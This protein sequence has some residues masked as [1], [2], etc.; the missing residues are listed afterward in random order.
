[1]WNTIYDKEGALVPNALSIFKNEL[2][3]NHQPITKVEFLH[4]ATMQPIGATL[5]SEPRGQV[6]NIISDG[7]IDVDVERGT[8]RTAEITLLN[9]SGDFTPGTAGFDP[10]GPWTGVVY[11]N[12]VVRI[13][14]GVKI[15]DLELY[16]PV[17]TFMVDRAETTVEQNMSLVNLTLSDFWK[18]LTKSSFS[19]NK[20]YD[21]GTSYWKVVKDM[22]NNS[23]VSSW[24]FSDL[25]DRDVSD[26]TTGNL[27][28][29]R[30]DV[31]GEKLK[32][33]GERW[34]L[35]FYFDPM[36]HFRADDR[37]A[38]RDKRTTWWFSSEP[39]D[40]GRHGGLVSITRS[41]SDD[42]IYNHVVVI[43]T[44]DEKNVVRETRTDESPSSKLSIE[45]LGRRTKIVESD[46]IST[47]NQAKRAISR[48]W[49]RR[50]RISETINADTICNPLLEAD[51]VVKFH[52][53]QFAKV[54]GTYRVRRFSV[55]L[56]TSKQT[57]EAE[58]Y[59]R[60]G[61]FK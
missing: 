24:T 22:L 21:K 45:K 15:G 53:P 7:N 13:W 31:R 50:N 55:P 35:D 2:R 23:G 33:L 30:G 3:F 40:D 49:N 58:N 28:F 11:L 14:R 5:F 9:P 34:D 60:S 46:K 4:T 38:P 10:D 16:A 37:L 61:D 27:K 20:K 26:R 19:A 48:L 12:R 29:S 17:G 42:Q 47:T 57:L 59:L 25:S 44:G 56:V 41:F 6:Q 1:M 32:E 36:G 18:K 43:G 39:V 51:D 52:E 54:T 8:R